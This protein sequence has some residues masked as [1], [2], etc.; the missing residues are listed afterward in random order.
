MIFFDE[1]HEIWRRIIVT[2]VRRPPHRGALL[3]RNGHLPHNDARHIILAQRRAENR[4]AR[5]I[6]PLRRTTAMRRG[7]NTALRRALF[8]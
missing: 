5:R 8:V 6:I 2:P 3:M 4:I 7:N 1:E